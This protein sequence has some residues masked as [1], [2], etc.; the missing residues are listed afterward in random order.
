MAVCNITALYQYGAHG[1]PL[2]KAQREGCQTIPIGDEEMD[3]APAL[4]ASEQP[5]RLNGP[6]RADD[7]LHGGQMRGGGSPSTQSIQDI[8]SFSKRLA[9]IM[10]LR[11]LDMTGDRA[12]SIRE[13]WHA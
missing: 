5:S 6:S 1:N 11:T 10:L 7:M 3:G 13:H 9:F 8:L 4:T 2:R 12:G